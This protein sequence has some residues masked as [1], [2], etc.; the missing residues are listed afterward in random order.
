M[1]GNRSNQ[2][3]TDLGNPGKERFKTTK[4]STSKFYQLNTEIKERTSG[5]D[6]TIE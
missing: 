2:D 6:D 4:N 5:T 1:T 3:S